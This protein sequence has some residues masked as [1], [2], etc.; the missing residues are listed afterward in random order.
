MNWSEF[1]N[2]MKGRVN[3]QQ[4]PIDTDALWDK[5]Q[6]KRR[7]PLLLWW[8]LSA[9]GLSVAGLLCWWSIRGTQGVHAVG[10]EKSPATEVV[11]DAQAQS[12]NAQRL[13]NASANGLQEAAQV[14]PKAEAASKPFATTKNTSDAVNNPASAAASKKTGSRLRVQNMVAVQGSQGA[15]IPQVSPA[16]TIEN[17]AK[18]PNLTTS[19]EQQ[20]SQ[21]EEPLHKVTGWLDFAT[22]PSR[23]VGV[24]MPAIEIPVPKT[25][26]L[27]PSPANT[28]T[29]NTKTSATAAQ[30]GL[31]LGY[32]RWQSTG[33]LP[34]HQANSHGLETFSLGLQWS[35]PVA[36]NWSVQTGLAYART[37]R[38]L[39]MERSWDI[40]Q[41]KA[42]TNYYADGSTA[43]DS[44]FVT[45][46]R[47]RKIKH[48]N[49][50]QQIGIPV[51]LQYRLAMGKGA[52]LPQLGLQAS[53]L[54]A[55]G[56]GITK[57]NEPDAKL[58]E[59]QYQQHFLLQAHAGF[60]WVFA[61]GKCC[62]VSVG[63]RFQFDLTPRSSYKLSHPER[64]WQGGVQVGVWFEL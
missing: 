11:Q 8:W 51:S 61:L 14:S 31:Q 39:S 56:I 5:L 4:T 44:F 37:T 53:W 12:V 22:I 57:A 64:F 35:K 36:K 40:Q 26:L 24:A 25:I 62:S 27:A 33:P 15:N 23:F 20:I 60:D 41:K 48:Y 9:A 45:V 28:Q 6:Q 1:E 34:T 52:L 13:P 18:A 10:H 63:P 2:D 17:A 58:F 46:E 19:S 3:E 59:N 47:T 38:L 30:F 54:R 32:D 50:W 43:I 7:K 21:V 55:K 49:R 29:V 16:K 42:T